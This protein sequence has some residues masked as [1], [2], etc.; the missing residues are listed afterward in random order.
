M[1]WCNSLFFFYYAYFIISSCI[2]LKQLK[3]L[4]VKLHCHFLF[5]MLEGHFCNCQG[6]SN[7]LGL[8]EYL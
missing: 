8:N 7:Y 6:I 1:L 4:A 2:M 5:K 3:R